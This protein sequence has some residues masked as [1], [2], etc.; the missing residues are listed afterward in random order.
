MISV[1]DKY[2]KRLLFDSNPYKKV[3]KAYNKEKEDFVLIN[4]FNKSKLN[5]SEEE[6][7]QLV[8]DEN[9]IETIKT[10]DNFYI[11]KEI[12]IFNLEEYMEFRNEPLS[13]D[14]IKEIL[15]Q[16]NDLIINNNEKK[17]LIFGCL[18]LSNI[19]IV[20]DKINRISIK[21]NTTKNYTN[22][23]TLAP[24]IINNEEDLSKSVLWCLGIIIYYLC[25]KEYP[26]NGKDEDELLKDIKSNKKLEK[27]ENFDNEELKDLMKKLLI[28]N[29]KERISWNEYF[30]HSFLQFQNI[31]NEILNLKAKIKFLKNEINMIKERDSGQLPLFKT[32]L[33]S[34]NN[35]T[36]RVYCLTLLN[37]GRLV[38]C[39]DDKSIII[40]NIINYEPDVIIK[41]HTSWIN[42]LTVLKNGILVSCSADK[43]IK[44]FDIQENKENKENKENNYKVIQTLNLHLDTVNTIIELTNDSLV[45]GSDDKQIIFYKK[46]DKEYE[47]DYPINTSHFVHNIIQTKQNE[48]AYSTYD[49]KINFFDFNEKK[50]LS[51]IDNITSSPNSFFIIRQKLLLIP[52]LNVIN[53]IDLNEYQV[54][55]KIDILEGGGL[56][57]GICMLN[58]NVIITGGE[59]GIIREWTIEGDNLILELESPKIV[60]EFTYSIVKMKNGHFASCN[61]NKTINIW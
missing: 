44:L 29:I 47:N 49:K 37:D 52:G 35:H 33:K 27:L 46:N 20:F 55:R 18:T 26:Y 14:E 48:I 45:S 41:E 16:L 39:S 32:P 24:E 5:L 50:E 15:N 61:E 56:V 60:N 8:K 58:S 21:L 19:L 17:Q 54:K 23:L 53:I 57:C 6:W 1:W 38:S 22:F 2:E 10:K 34:L 4:E 11:I 36:E 30:N 42:C 3:Y 28:I 51:H 12:S 43:T 25:F 31:G 40:Y 59:N 7:K 9:P 13:I